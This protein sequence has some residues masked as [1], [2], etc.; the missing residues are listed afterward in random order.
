MTAGTC[1][2]A[3]ATDRR[4]RALSNNLLDF[5]SYFLMSLKYSGTNSMVISSPAM[6]EFSTAR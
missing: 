6:E 3:L 2:D 5:F 4:T 1:A